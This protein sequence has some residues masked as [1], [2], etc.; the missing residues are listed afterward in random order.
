LLAETEAQLYNLLRLAVEDRYLI[1]AQVPLWC[2]LDL[3]VPRSTPWNEMLR[4]LAL[5]R[6]T[7]VLVHPGS[8]KVEKVVQVDHPGADELSR[9]GRDAVVESAFAAAGVQ[10]VHVRT[11]SA[12]TVPALITA[13]DLGEPE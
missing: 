10:V 5:Q 13:L 9:R 11:D 7:F 8:R 12:Y 1:F 6:A 3:H 4:E 2:V